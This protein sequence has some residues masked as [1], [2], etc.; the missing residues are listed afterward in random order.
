MGYAYYRL[1]GIRHIPYSQHRL[2]LQDVGAVMMTC[3]CGG[4]LMTRD[5][6]RYNET[7]DWVQRRRKCD[8]C[9]TKIVT[10]EIPRDELGWEYEDVPDKG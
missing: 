1:Q 5:T 7:Q 9:G 10:L 4:R 3:K 6:R 2:S 8:S